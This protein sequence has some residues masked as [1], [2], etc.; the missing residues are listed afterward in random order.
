MEQLQQYCKRYG[1]PSL[2]KLTGPRRAFP[3]AITDYPKSYWWE[4]TTETVSAVGDACSSPQATPMTVRLPSLPENIV[5]ST[6]PKE[7]VLYGA[8]G[9]ETNDG[10]NYYAVPQVF[11]PNMNR[12]RSSFPNDA[13]L[14]QCKLRVDSL[15]DA[16]VDEKPASKMGA[17]FITVTETRIETNC[18][19][20]IACNVRRESSE[21]GGL[22]GAPE[23]TAPPPP[24]PTAPDS[25]PAQAPKASMNPANGAQPFVSQRPHK[26]DIKGDT[27]RAEGTLAAG[28]V[29]GANRGEG[30]AG[31][32]TAKTEHSAT[33]LL[34]PTASSN[35]PPVSS[36]AAPGTPPA[37]QSAAPG[38]ASAPIALSMVTAMPQPT[39]TI[40]QAPNAAPA[41]PPLLV[42]NSAMSVLPLVTMGAHTEESAG[43]QIGTKTVLLGETIT[44]NNHPIIV[45]TIAGATYAVIQDVQGGR[46]A[47][48]T[49]AL[50][51]LPNAGLVGDE[52]AVFAPRPA[53]AATGIPTITAFNIALTPVRDGSFSVS[54][55]S[56]KINGPPVTLGNGPTPT[57]LS[58][59]TN[60]AGQGILVANGVSATLTDVLFPSETTDWSQK[61]AAY[62]SAAPK[63]NDGVR[64]RPYIWLCGW[65]VIWGL[66]AR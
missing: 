51:N 2:T 35:K 52:G 60:T 34:G 19:P 32:M 30:V 18:H 53:A 5:E 25:N 7:P 4:G 6:V 48:S 57:T 13:V 45:T 64:Q 26:S 29:N 44:I 16:G 42:G 31:V 27:L 9:G 36:D 15:K 33:G 21:T 50:N 62:S 47:A 8:E 24:Q 1:I 49:I 3:T 58:L 61:P 46:N 20:G 43:F 28:A 39:L 23:H 56:L 14:A 12:Y 41:H 40:L 37:E 59:T 65:T 54:G 55:T 10:T 66:L 38:P 63:P 17:L 22:V 11:P